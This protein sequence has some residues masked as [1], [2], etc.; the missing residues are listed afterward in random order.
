M[1]AYPIQN[2]WRRGCYLARLTGPDPKYIIAREFITG[3]PVKSRG[4][5][6]YEPGRDLPEDPSGWYAMRGEAGTTVLVEAGPLE[7]HNHGPKDSREMLEIVGA[8]EWTCADDTCN[9]PADGG[10]CDGCGKAEA[11]RADTDAM[12]GADVVPF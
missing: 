8:G 7:W 6:E 9:N 5:L 12:T 11:A 2:D 3:T 1:T 4:L 10:L